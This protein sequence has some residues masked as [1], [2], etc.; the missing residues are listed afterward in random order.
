M[1]DR[2]NGTGVHWEFHVPFGQHKRLIQVIRN[3]FEFNGNHT[4]RHVATVYR[5]DVETHQLFYRHAHPDDLGKE[6]DGTY[7]HIRANYTGSPPSDAVSRRAESNMDH[8]VGDYLWKDGDSTLFNDIHNE[9]N[10][11]GDVGTGL[12]NWMEQNNSEASCASI[13][14]F[15]SV[16]EGGKIPKYE[17]QGVFAYGWNDK[18]FGFN[19]RAGGWIDQCN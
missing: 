10:I 2:D 13:R 9:D 19:G 11:V 8:V 14:T 5:H 12:A 1:T 7:H 15:V 16:S 18:P 3:E 17:D 4:F 6:N